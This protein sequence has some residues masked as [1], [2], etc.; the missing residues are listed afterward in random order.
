[1]HVEGCGN[2]ESCLNPTPIPS[3][4]LKS[5]LGGK[6]GQGSKVAGLHGQPYPLQHYRV[7]HKARESDGS[8]AILEEEQSRVGRKP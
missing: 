1:M 8:W 5:V 7:G 6:V 3:S 2:S 4:C